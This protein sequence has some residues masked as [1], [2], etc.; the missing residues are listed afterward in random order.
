MLKSKKNL[1][2][3]PLSFLLVTALLGSGTVIPQTNKANAAASTLSAT[4][5]IDANVSQGAL[6]R[7]EQYFNIAKQST[8]PEAQ[9]SRSADIQFLNDQGLHTKIQRAWLNESE[10]YDETTGLFNKY[11]KI[12]TYLSL[13]SN[14]GDELLINLRAEK[15]IKEFEYTPAQI[16]PIVKDYIKHIKQQFPKIKYLEVTNEPDA[17]PNSDANYYRIDPV[18]KKQTSTNILSPSNYYSYYKAFSDAVNEINAELNPSVPLQ[19]GGPA[20]FNFDLEWL[21]GFLDGYKND[22]SPTKKLDF[23]SYHG[24]LRKDP[25]TGRYLFYKD[26]PTMAI[27]ERAQLEAELSSRGISTDIPSFITES[28]M[29]PGS[30]T[31]TPDSSGGVQPDQ[32]RQ[33]AGMASQ[34][35]WYS[36][37]SSKNY[38]FGWNVRH[39]GGNGRKDSLVSRD[40]YNKL[41]NP[42]YSDKFTPYGN[43]RE[44]QAKMK[45]TK[46]SAN[47]DSIDDK[48]K[49]VYALAAK[50]ETGLSLMVWNYQGR[51]TK[52]YDAAVN[53]SNL[54][55]IF[56]GKN[57]RVK[58]YKI[59]SKTSNYFVSLDNSNLQMVDDKI[60]T[61][62]GDYATSLQFEPNSLQL[63]VLEPVSKNVFLHNSFNDEV[64]GA[65]PGWIVTEPADTAVS[66]ANV[67]S[68]ANRSVHLSDNSSV[69]AA[70]IS[71]SFENQSAAITAQWRFKE[72]ADLT[73]DRFQVK[74]GD[75]VAIDIYVNEAGSL[76]ANGNVIQS[77]SPS[78]WYTVKLKTNSVSNKYEIFV[79]DTP[80]AVEIPYS[81]SVQGLDTISFSTGEA[82]QS[83]LYIDDVAVY[84]GSVPFNLG[85]SSSK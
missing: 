5:S 79:D 74:S 2:R 34:A 85:I 3:K 41:L 26:N 75:T 13:V 15:V 20:L 29:Y 36:A 63:L 52:D 12:D 45:T 8:Y 47:S 68:V 66:I 4:V 82:S 23:I 67:P 69:H 27:D 6:F 76:V 61:H 49:G 54:P 81:A 60:V 70:Q 38:P 57:V 14:M 31:D 28:G 62:K 1:K 48:G 39:N 24:Y 80:E 46:V 18:T 50:D 32:L 53:V 7:S 84:R 64:T 33:A 43:M 44:M 37:S 21:K 22:T 55:S 58:T 42:I 16:K 9:A 11:N 40:S 83:S 51:D 30:L 35:Y 19:V 25:S 59:D 72:D 78:T 65:D 17:P 10:I 56:N 71:K 77:V 73:N